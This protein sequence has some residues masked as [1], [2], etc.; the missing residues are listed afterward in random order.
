MDYS[1]EFLQRIKSFGLIGWDIEKILSVISLSGAEKV[2]FVADFGD[3]NSVVYAMY[4]NGLNTE[5]NLAAAE[6][7]A[8]MAEAEAVQLKN[9]REKRYQELERKL[10]G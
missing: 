1:A 7:K 8:K 9:E 5:F 6:Y 2:Q 4:H 10:F 3:E